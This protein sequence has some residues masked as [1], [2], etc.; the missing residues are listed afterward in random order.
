MVPPPRCGCFAAARAPSPQSQS[1]SE[2]H[3]LVH[4]RAG[5]WR[6]WSSSSGSWKKGCLEL[7]RGGSFFFVIMK[8]IYI[9]LSCTSMHYVDTYIRYIYRYIYIYIT[10]YTLVNLQTLYNEPYIHSLKLELAYMCAGGD[11]RDG[12]TEEGHGGSVHNAVF[13]IVYIYIYI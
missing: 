6:F 11:V 12:P 2:F 5:G 4:L 1:T 9:Y 10:L 7:L 8:S 3:F 13:Y